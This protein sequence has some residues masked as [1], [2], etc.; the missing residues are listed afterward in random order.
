MYVFSPDAGAQAYW[1]PFNTTN[2]VELPCEPGT[3]SANA[4]R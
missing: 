4:V 3:A 1:D 2:S